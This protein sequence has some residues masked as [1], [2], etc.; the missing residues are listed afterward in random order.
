M[1][2][3]VRR[4]I[5]RRFGPL[6]DRHEWQQQELKAGPQQLD[7]GGDEEGERVSEAVGQHATERRRAAPAEADDGSEGL[8]PCTRVA[9]REV[10]HDRCVERLCA[11]HER[12]ARQVDA[13]NQQHLVRG[14]TPSLQAVNQPKVSQKGEGAQEYNAEHSVEKHHLHAADA[15]RECG[16]GAG[17]DGHEERKGGID[18]LHCHRGPAAIGKDGRVAGA[19]LQSGKGR[20]RGRGHHSV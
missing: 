11:I 5:A 2:R 15:A 6:L 16:A 18:Q 12:G 1:A 14:H 13:D 9:R 4:R 8:P 3:R 17:A 20:G 7:A 19:Q 10:H